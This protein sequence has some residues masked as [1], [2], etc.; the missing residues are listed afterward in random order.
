MF[1]WFSTNLLVANAEK[2]HLLTSSK[3]LVGIHISDTEIL[4]EEK[5]KLLTVNLE[6]RVNIGFQVNTLFKKSK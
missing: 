1:H 5:L 2:C 6:D 3:T 4:N